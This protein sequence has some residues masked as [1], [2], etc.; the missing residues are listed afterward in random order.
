MPDPIEPWIANGSFK[1]GSIDMYSTF[2]LQL[3]GDSMDE[4]LLLPEVRTRK[5]TIPLRHGEYDYGSKYRKERPLRMNC[6]SLSCGS[7]EGEFRAFAREIA[8]VLSKKDRIRRW[9]EPD[10]YY[11]GKVEK[12]ITLTQLRDVGNVFTLDFT[13]EPFAYG[14]TVSKPFTNLQLVPE[15]NGTAESPTYIE[16]TNVGNANAAKIRISQVD[17]KDNY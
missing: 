13:C 12:E 9:Y 14:Q 3:M 6:V 8:Y 17:R 1:F 15:Y 11:I 10:V 16:I 5:I 7:T 2:G 4:D